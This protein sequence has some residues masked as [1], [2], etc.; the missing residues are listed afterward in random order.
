EKDLLYI[1]D[2]WNRI[3]EFDS[4]SSQEFSPFKVAALH[5]WGLD[6]SG[7]LQGAGGVGGLLATQTDTGQ[8]TENQVYFYDGN[9]NVTQTYDWEANTYSHSE[10][11]AFGNL[12]EG[13]AGGFGFSTK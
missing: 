6:L 1:Y 7:T 9:G 13:A 12:I 2:G 8:G 11:D 3:A 5:T 4:L 10:Y